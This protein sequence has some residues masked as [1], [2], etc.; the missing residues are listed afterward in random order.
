MHREVFELKEYI[1]SGR[2]RGR[3]AY[4]KVFELEGCTGKWS[5]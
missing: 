4:R 3:G 2:V 1:G 5:G